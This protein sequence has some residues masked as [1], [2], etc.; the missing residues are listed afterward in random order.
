MYSNIIKRQ[1]QFILHFLC[2][3]N[4]KLKLGSSLYVFLYCI[5]KVKIVHM[6]ICIHSTS[7]DAQLFCNSPKSGNDDVTELLMGTV[8]VLEILNV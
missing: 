6:H 2:R 7:L 1:S 8:D 5:I 3:I 4:K